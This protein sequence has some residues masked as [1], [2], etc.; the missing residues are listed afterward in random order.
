MNKTIKI[1]IFL[2]IFSI[3]YNADLVAEAN[4]NQY[5]EKTQETM[6]VYASGVGKSNPTDI[7]NIPDSG[8]LALINDTLGQNYA[9]DVTVAQMES[10]EEL[11]DDESFYSIDSLEGIEYAVNLKKLSI[12]G[13][14]IHSLSPLAGLTSLTNLEIG[15]M[16][17]TDDISPLSGLINLTELDLNNG[18]V[19]DLSPISGLTNLTTLDL[20]YTNVSDL[21]PI[22]GLTNLTTL[23]LY[24]AI[25]SDLS[26]ISGLTNL[27]TLD[28]SY[29]NVNDLSPISGLTNLTTLK[30]NHA[31]VTNIDSISGLTNLTT[32]I[33]SQN[34]INDVSPIS[35]LT[36][37]TTLDAWGNQI[38]DVSP[39]SGLINLTYL[40][41]TENDIKDL[42]SLS[43]LTNLE[44]L[45]LM[46]NEI[47]DIS[48]ISEMNNLVALNINNN[49]ISDV[50]VVSK[51]PN[52]QELNAKNQV[53]SY[54][55][56]EIESVS[57]WGYY[58]KDI[59]GNNVKATF[60]DNIKLG[61]NTT[62][63][64]WSTNNNQFTGKVNYSYSYNGEKPQINGTKDITIM[65]GDKVDLLAG[66]SASD[67]EDGN[68]TN[69]IIVDD[70]KV[71]YNK[72]GNYDVIYAITDSSG[73][74]TI[75]TITLSIVRDI[76][77]PV[78]PPT[79]GVGVLPVIN[80]TKDITLNLGDEINLL[81]GISATDGDDGDLT[82]KII[83]D[84]SKVNYNKAGIYVVTY[85]V[86]DSDGNMITKTINL[87][88]KRDTT[89]PAKPLTPV[90][91]L[92]PV[93]DGANDITINIGDK[94]DYLKGL[95]A[96]DFEDG[97]LTSSIIVD[98]S[99][100]DYSKPG[101]YEVTYWVTDSAGNTISKKI[102]ITVKN[103]TIQTPTEPTEPINPVVPNQENPKT[104]EQLEVV[105]PTKNL[106]VKDPKKPKI[107]SEEKLKNTGNKLHIIGLVS[108]PV[109][110]SGIYLLKRKL[111]NK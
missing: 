65:L 31:N 71:N 91:D 52:L 61:N 25:I 92:A 27:T 37:L 70:S 48:C 5:T 80:G 55:A 74:T 89:S 83:V 44:A 63:G 54:D 49:H 82:G 24:Y 84:D 108:T 64:Q 3:G 93:I 8:L 111:M 34:K 85:S 68:L 41:L 51:F 39:I 88:I 103:Q 36:N 59:N 50:S 12:D 58:V 90:I 14:N 109:L 28:F 62:S 57:E 105:K 72:T 66:I 7:V 22:S 102:F 45:F 23:N 30:F 38:V 56:G 18:I 97:D 75:E 20:S 53:I 69:K 81:L 67:V 33:I 9:A 110:L 29:T 16:R 21:S 6:N 95:S 98:D 47:S 4:T 106:E 46:R 87:T 77:T 96:S 94:A 32:L 86:T 99:K 76:T 73:K 79:P 2:M 100:V 101:K 17:S 35:G 104:P 26:P 15:R 10:L 42:S 19:E 78:T 107:S 43:N 60:D 11:S 1:T 40:D 13:Y